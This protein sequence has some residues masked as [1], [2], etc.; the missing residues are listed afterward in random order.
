MSL[1]RFEEIQAWQEARV[2]VRNIYSATKRPAF[3]RDKGLC[4]QIQR[5]AVSCMANTAEGFRK[6][7]N[8]EF[9]HYLNHAIASGNEVESH[10]YVALDLGYLSQ[11]QFD[12]LFEQAELFLKLANGFS[13]YLKKT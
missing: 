7:S 11:L 1:K 2:L 4:Q 8:R 6:G 9:V 3:T 13:S 10:L 5:A 12:K